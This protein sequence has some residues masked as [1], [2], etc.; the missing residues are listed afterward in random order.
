MELIQLKE[1]DSICHV[2]YSFSVPLFFAPVLL[3][4]IKIFNGC[5]RTPI[6]FSHSTGIPRTNSTRHVAV[7]FFI[8]LYYIHTYLAHEYTFPRHPIH[9]RSTHGNSSA[10]RNAQR[11]IHSDGGIRFDQAKNHDIRV[12][13]VLSCIRGK[14][15]IYYGSPETPRHARFSA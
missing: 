10:P 4:W 11:T 12:Y 14:R 3:F 13:N 15:K 8:S 6:A 7:V 5:T 1:Y 2:P 9:S